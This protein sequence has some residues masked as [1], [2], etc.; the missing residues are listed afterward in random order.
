M[1]HGATSPWSDHRRV[2]LL[3]GNDLSVPPSVKSTPA[4]FPGHAWLGFGLAG[5]ERAQAGWSRVLT[6]F[7]NT[8]WRAY[9]PKV[10]Y[11]P[12]PECL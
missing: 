4:G 1:P 7:S 3:D 10:L 9:F 12:T 2:V 8:E 5:G 11:S 6:T